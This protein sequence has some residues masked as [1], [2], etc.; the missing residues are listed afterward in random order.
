M[1]NHTYILFVILM[2]CSDL[3]K[4]DGADIFLT[5]IK[6]ERIN[7]KNY[8][9]FKVNRYF[10]GPKSKIRFEINLTDTLT[11]NN[12]KLDSI[13]YINTKNTFDSSYK[14]WSCEITGLSSDQTIQKLRHLKKIISKDSLITP[15]LGCN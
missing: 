15:C 3:V 14:Q 13:I 7:S 4:R 8:S 2:G 10:I 5:H 11:I 12:K 9:F 1:K 6:T